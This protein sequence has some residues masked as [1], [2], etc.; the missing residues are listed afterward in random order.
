MR[1]LNIS[2]RK[3]STEKDKIRK[4]LNHTVNTLDGMPPTIE[5]SSF[6]S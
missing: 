3:R 5:E 2:F 1:R 4:D 6:T